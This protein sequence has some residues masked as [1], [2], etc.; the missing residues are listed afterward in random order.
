VGA[1]HATSHIDGETS[2]GRTALGGLMGAVA[3]SHGNITVG[4]ATGGAEAAINSAARNR[5]STIFVNVQYSSG[6][7]RGASTFGLAHGGILAPS[8]VPRMA[9]G[10]VQSFGMAGIADVA[11]PNSMRAIYG[12]RSD[13]NESYI[14]WNRDPRSLAILAL[15]ARAM[16]RQLLPTRS[17]NVYATAQSPQAASAVTNV[18]NHVQLTFQNELSAMNK[19]D[20]RQVAVVVQNALD[21]LTRS[22]R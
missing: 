17:N 4:A 2:G 20:L 16:G 21:D 9:P 5:F 15:T 6:T 10:G 18:V 13:V 8:G 12:D 22:R 11:P 7:G 1:A 14:P 19:A 3:G